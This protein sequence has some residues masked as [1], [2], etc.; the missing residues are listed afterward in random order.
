MG[1]A[2]VDAGDNLK[3][4][5]RMDGASLDSVDTSVD[6]IR[7]TR[8][9]NTPAP[10]L[11]AASQPGKG[12]YSTE[13]INNGPVISDDGEL[14]KNKD[15]IIVGTVGVSGGNVAEDTN[16]VKAGVVAFRQPAE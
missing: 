7:T 15:G 1:I 12:L 6:K 10:A 3:A 11:G 4:F 9:F 5:I 8:L 2:V 13:V 16:V 14:L